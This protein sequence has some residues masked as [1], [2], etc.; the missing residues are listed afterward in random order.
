MGKKSSNAFYIAAILEHIGDKI[1]IKLL[2]NLGKR[3][4]EHK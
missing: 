4:G 3:C 2:Q 1:L